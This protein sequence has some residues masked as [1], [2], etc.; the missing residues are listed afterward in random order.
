MDPLSEVISLLN[1]RA[2]R[3]TRFE[4]S[5]NWSYRFPAKPAL[6]FGAILKGDCWMDFGTGVRHHLSAGD[7]FLLAN[8]PGYVLANDEQAL[9]ADGIAMFDWEHSDV[10]RHEGDDTVLVA[11]SFQFDASDAELLLDALPQILI[12]PGGHPSA[13]AI[14]STLQIIAPE[15]K[16]PQIGAAL[17]TERLVDVLLV[18]V[19]RAAL[20]LDR[21]TDFGWIG[22]LADPRIG[23]AIGL[24]HNDPAHPWTLEILCA[25]VA[26][27]RS[28]FSKRFKS[29]VGRAPLDYL[30]H[31]RMRIARD[32]LRRGASVAAASLHIGYASESA[33]RHAFKR[34][35][36]NA[37]KRYRASF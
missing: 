8:A 12:I 18:L 36:G 33:F 34:L 31:W 4:A 22:A 9:P 20:E 35:H 25:A 19:L 26:M 2:A 14:R 5:G 27:S 37:P 29:L 3:C 10:A 13:A 21:S 6:K 11:G 15:I 1:V 24:M 7:S 30:L 28:A 32:Q 23:K 16:G 17:L